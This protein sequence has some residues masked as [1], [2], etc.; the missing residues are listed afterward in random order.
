[1]KFLPSQFIMFLQVIFQANLIIKES[2]NKKDYDWL[3]DG[4]ESHKESE[5]SE[6]QIGKG[7]GKHALY[8]IGLQEKE[9]TH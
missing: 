1:M 3:N 8:Q 7:E 6:A 5:E 9:K 4:V 2:R